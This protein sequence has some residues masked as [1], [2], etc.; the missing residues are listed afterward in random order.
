MRGLAMTDV[1]DDSRMSEARERL[2]LAPEAGAPVG[3]GHVL[4]RDDL[5]RP[6]V[7]GAV[8]R[9][10]RSTSNLALDPIRPRVR[11]AAATRG[12]RRALGVRRAAGLVT[13]HLGELSY[14]L[15]ARVARLD[16]PLD[17]RPRR[18]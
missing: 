9:A 10:R 14:E 13:V 18:G 4:E 7:D 5:F 6:V 11:E 17:A 16:V 1:A 3:I 12:D 8:D 15:T 2:D